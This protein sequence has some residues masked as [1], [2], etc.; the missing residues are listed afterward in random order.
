MPI[1]TTHFAETSL[2]SGLL[3]TPSPELIVLVNEALLPAPKES[4]WFEW[5]K[6]GTYFANM[7][8]NGYILYNEETDLL[9]CTKSSPDDLIVCHLDG[10]DKCVLDN[11]AFGT[12]N[13]FDG[14][15]YYMRQDG[16]WKVKPDGT[17]KHLI[18][19]KP[20]DFFT[21]QLFVYDN[22]VYLMRDYEETIF[23]SDL[24]GKNEKSIDVPGLIMGFYYFDNGYLYYGSTDENN[25]AYNIVKY[26]LSV[27][28]AKKIIACEATGPLIVRNGMLYCINNGTLVH[29]DGHISEPVVNDNIRVWDNNYNLYSNYLF[30]FKND[31]KF[32]SLDAGMLYA[33]NVNTGQEYELFYVE[34]EYLTHFYVMENSVLLFSGFSNDIIYQITFDSDM[35]YLSKLNGISF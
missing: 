26:E 24:E 7:I 17:E 31:Y 10:T 20:L 1:Q 21:D 13:Y 27:G 8:G 12:V 19:E 4:E 18:I 32:G 14:W 2:T 5:D 22:S 25:E 16:V 30:Y 35:A 6:A 9:I 23:S 28:K 29:T 34:K 11:V 3:P 33:L 15:I